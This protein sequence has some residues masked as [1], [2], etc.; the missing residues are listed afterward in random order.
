M[1][2][3]GYIHDTTVHGYADGTSFMLQAATST[4]PHSVLV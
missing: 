4:L 1:Y 2:I 3:Y